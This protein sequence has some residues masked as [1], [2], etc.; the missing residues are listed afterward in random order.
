[1]SFIIIL[2]SIWATHSG[3]ENS[4]KTSNTPP[5]PPILTSQYSTCN[6]HDFINKRMVAMLVVICFPCMMRT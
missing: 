1:M 5:K 4:L 6:N 2:T 3:D